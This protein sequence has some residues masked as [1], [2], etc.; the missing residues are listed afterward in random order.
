M[1]LNERFKDIFPEGT[2]RVVPEDWKSQLKFSGLDQGLRIRSLR[3]PSKKMSKSDGDPAG[4]ITLMEDPKSAVKK[5][6]AA[7]TDSEGVIR[8]N[9]KTQPGISNLLQMLA[10]FQ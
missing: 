6:M 1:R 10:L 3:N 9:W 4:F 7:S 2:F 5:I 8:F